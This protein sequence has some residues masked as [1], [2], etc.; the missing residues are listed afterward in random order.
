M[1]GWG[2][3]NSLR[4]NGPRATSFGREEKERF[5]LYIPNIRMWLL[6]DIRLSFNNGRTTFPHVD[7]RETLLY[8][9]TLFLLFASSSCEQESRSATAPGAQMK[10]MDTQEGDIADTVGSKELFEERKALWLK[11]MPHHYRLGFSFICDCHHSTSQLQEVTKGGKVSM[12]RGG[13]LLTIE[14]RDGKVIGIRKED[15]EQ[16]L[17]KEH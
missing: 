8:L 2:R 17:V 6:G 15:G 3:T 10:V 11:N 13:D 5:P 16:I 4:K 7:A 9:S 12:E 1:A 14:V